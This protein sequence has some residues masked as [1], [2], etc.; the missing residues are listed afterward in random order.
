MKFERKLGNGITIL[1]TALVT[2][3]SRERRNGFCANEI[4]I[5]LPRGANSI[6]PIR[7]GFTFSSWR[8]FEEI[9]I[10]RGGV[11]DEILNGIIARNEIIT[12]LNCVARRFLDVRWLNL[13]HIA[14]NDWTNL[15]RL[16]NFMISPSRSFRFTLCAVSRWI[17]RCRRSK[18]DRPNIN[19]AFDRTRLNA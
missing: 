10:R 9:L 18:I 15:F 2:I 12:S 17:C 4:P 19:T 13:W 1:L 6:F 7:E 3:L 14:D 5:L 8:E 11:N 16:P